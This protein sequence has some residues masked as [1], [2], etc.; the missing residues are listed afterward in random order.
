M[1]VTLAADYP[2]SWCQT[3]TPY[4]NLRQGVEWW[5]VPEMLALQ[6]LMEYFQ[7]GLA[8]EFQASLG[9]TE[10]YKDPD[11]KNRNRKNEGRGGTG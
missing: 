10:R 9:Y 11:L 8:N 5:S 7:V 4:Q 1:N 2:V 6:R 3:P